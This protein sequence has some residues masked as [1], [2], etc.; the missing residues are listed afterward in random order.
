MKEAL[1]KIMQNKNSTFTNKWR[2]FDLHDSLKDPRNSFK[3][4]FGL[5]LFFVLCRNSR[6]DNYK[7]LCSNER[8]IPFFF[9]NTRGLQLTAHSPQSLT[10]PG[11]V[12][13]A[14][15]AAFWKF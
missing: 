5:C 3:I 10:H 8:V 1:S 15:Q 6:K 12:R 2:F 7:D 13:A 9:A 14:K 4:L 11:T